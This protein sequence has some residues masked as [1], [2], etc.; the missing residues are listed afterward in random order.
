M[1]QAS[2]I[3]IEAWGFHRIA[4]VGIQLDKCICGHTVRLL[5]MW[6]YI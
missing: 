3:S 6:A 4:Y 1:C 5:Y 2:S